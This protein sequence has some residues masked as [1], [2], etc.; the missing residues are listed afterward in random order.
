MTQ[1][2]ALKL[3]QGRKLELGKSPCLMG[4]L[5]CTPDSF[6][7]GGSCPSPEKA[8][9]RALSLLADGA[10]IIDIGGESTRPGSPALPADEEI[11]RV[12]P[13]IELLRKARPDCAISVD[14]RKLEVARAA[15]S[16][17]ADLVNDV[18]GL[19]F[20]PGIAELASKEGAALCLMHM[21]G[22]PAT[23]QSPENLIYGDLIGEISGFLSAA[24]AKAE[25]CGVARDSIVL[26]PGLGFSKSLEQN[27]TIMR[28]MER[29]HALG[30]PLLVGPSRK[31]FIGKLS[32]EPDAA[33]RDYGTCGAVAALALRGV[34]I[35][36]VHNVKA[37]RQALA[38]FS[39][40]VE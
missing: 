18:S 31:T 13:V 9:E 30:Y 33:S 2:R 12:A 26:D 17:G 39:A 40:C 16:A 38:V 6:S 28:E 27:V 35:I 4:V 3:R 36:R 21:R 23:M 22:T 15:L 24:A 34:Q 11:S 7:D 8:L 32:D 19:Q 10:A 14:T 5:N 1:P 37:A 25:S 29:F 20:D